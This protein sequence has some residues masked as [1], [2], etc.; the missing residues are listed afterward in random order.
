M[1]VTWVRLM[2]LVAA[3]LL[4]AGADSRRLWV[5]LH[6][7]LSTISLWTQPTTG[8]SSLIA[9]NGIASLDGHRR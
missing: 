8:R 4:P 9:G 5:M 7:C 2:P 6:S 3:R 1:H